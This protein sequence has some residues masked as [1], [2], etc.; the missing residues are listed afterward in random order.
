MSKRATSPVTEPSLRPHPSLPRPRRTLRRRAWPRCPLEECSRP[1]LLERPLRPQLEERRV[2]LEARPRPLRLRRVEERVL[3]GW[4]LTGVEW[5]VGPSPW[6]VSS[7]EPSPSSKQLSLPLERR[8]TDKAD[9]PRILLP[10]FDYTL[11]LPST[12][13]C[14]SFHTQRNPPSPHPLSFDHLVSHTFGLCTIQKSTVIRLV[15]SICYRIRLSHPFTREVRAQLE[16]NKSDEVEQ[17]SSLSPPDLPPEPSTRIT[18]SLKQSYS[19]RRRRMSL[20]CPSAASSV[21]CLNISG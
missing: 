18:Q 14:T 9:A 21:G 6:W 8:H 12:V 20:N 13:S 4:S 2:R 17:R 1:L 15:H 10:V 16:R 19:S 7:Q 11:A 5:S 3:G